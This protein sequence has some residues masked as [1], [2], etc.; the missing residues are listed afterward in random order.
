[1]RRLLFV[2]LLFIALKLEAIEPQ[3]VYI[4]NQDQIINELRRIGNNISSP[5]V[6]ATLVAISSNDVSVGTTARIN[7]NGS[8]LGNVTYFSSNVTVTVS[9]PESQTAS[10]MGTISN[11]IVTTNGA[12]TNQFVITADAIDVMGCFTQYLSTSLFV[13]LTGAGGSVDDSAG[14]WYQAWVIATPLCSTF[15][16]ISASAN[17]LN[18]SM[19]SGYTK[20]RPIFQFYNDASAN[21]VPIFKRGR[22]VAYFTYQEIVNGVNPTGTETLL[23]F[24]N[25]LSP[26]SYHAYC[27]MEVV[28]TNAGL[29]LRFIG[30]IPA[31][32]ANADFE[33]SGIGMSAGTSLNVPID[34]SVYASKIA[35]YKEVFAASQFSVAVRGYDEEY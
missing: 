15:S 22:Y 9:A 30:A 31:N 2:P 11:L 12:N 28:G 26:K 27:S 24:S 1:M 19:P 7:F 8:A 23:N 32:F 29:W 17:I 35:Y 14:Q 10:T 13:N 25:Y 16:V 18:P 5:T 21:I 4:I 33:S 34:F 3:N 20:Y 6:A